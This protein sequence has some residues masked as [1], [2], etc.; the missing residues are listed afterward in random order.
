MASVG[1][2][3]CRPIIT[4]GMEIMALSFDVM[5]SL[6]IHTM[7]LALWACQIYVRCILAVII[8]SMRITSRVA[9][10]LLATWLAIAHMVA[11][12]FEKLQSD[13]LAHVYEFARMSRHPSPTDDRK[14]GANK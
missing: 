14:P 10:S 3:L 7:L 4:I 12:V 2:A 5:Q 1:S 6:W 11:I 8:S 9:V 13:V